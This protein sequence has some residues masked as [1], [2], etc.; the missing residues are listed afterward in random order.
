[1]KSFFTL[2]LIVILKI[3]YNQSDIV[4]IRGDYLW[5]KTTEV[6]NKEY[7]FFLDDLLKQKD[8]VSYLNYYPDS[9]TWNNPGSFN[10]SFVKYYFKHPAYTNYP[11]TSI[12]HEGALAYCNWLTKKINAKNKEAEVLVRLPT[13]KEWE[14]A[15]RGGQDFAVYPWGTEFVRFKKGRNK[16]K[17]QANFVRGK[18]DYMGVAGALNDGADI[19]APVVSYWKNPYGIYNMSGNA[20]EMV[21]EKGITKGGSWKDRGDDLMIGKRQFVDSASCEVGFRFV[22]E[23]INKKLPNKTPRE[24]K[25]NKSFFK[26]YFY[27][28]TDSVYCG[29]YEVTNQ[30]YN[31]FVSG[32]GSGNAIDCDGWLNL[33]PYSN[34]WANN[35]HSHPVFKNYPVVNV[36]KINAIAFCNWLTVKYNGLSKKKFSKVKFRLPTEQEWMEAASVGGRNLPY[37]WNEKSLKDIN[38]NYLANFNPKW[39]NSEN[40]SNQESV[41]QHHFFFNYFTDLEDFDGFAVTAPVNSYSSN[42]MGVY[43]MSGNVAEMVS[44]VDVTKGGSWGDKSDYLQ[45]QVKKQYNGEPSPFVGFR[46]FMEVLEK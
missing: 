34:Y 23:V 45:V 32:T 12:T 2:L 17:M 4:P 5:I 33:F 10:E 30:L 9:L 40:I 7:Q 38:G 26:T 20:E 13:E 22:V 15:A 3:G 6:S 16:G 18:G 35:Y 41:E 14:W 21:V 31:I 28:V 27:D 29:K 11:V 37:A 24:L 46:V 42:Q 43:C 19:T 39:K 36:S 44:D 8:N 1:M 25:I